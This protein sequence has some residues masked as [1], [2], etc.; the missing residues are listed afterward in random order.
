MAGVVAFAFST[1]FITLGGEI[2]PQAYFSRN[3]LRMASLMSPLLRVYQVVLYPIAKPSALILDAWIGKETIAF[4]PEV[5]IR[6]ALKQHVQSPKSDVGEVEGLGAINFLLLDDL[7]MADVGEPVDPASVLRLPHDDGRPVFPAFEVSPDDPFLKQVQG[8]GKRWV[9][10]AAADGAPT[11][12][13]DASAFL[14]AAMFIPE[15][16]DPRDY[17][18]RPVTVTED[19]TRLGDAIAKLRAMP[20]DEVIDQDLILLWGQEKRVITGADL[21]GFLLRDIA[22][23]GS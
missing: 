5:E 7:R 2:F 11:T 3:A 14:R 13:L 21:L 18:H 17:C 10:I 22:H 19:R 4:V 6:E 1:F 23:P 9:L 20:G 15:P 12:A 16:V 8:S